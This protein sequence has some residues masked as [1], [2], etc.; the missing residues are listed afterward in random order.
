M[1]YI[2]HI[3]LSL[4]KGWEWC[5]LILHCFLIYTVFVVLCH[6]YV[7]YNAMHKYYINGICCRGNAVASGIS[8]CLMVELHQANLSSDHQKWCSRSQQNIEVRQGTLNKCQVFTVRP[9]ALKSWLG[10]LW[11]DGHQTR[12]VKSLRLSTLLLGVWL[13]AVCKTDKAKAITHQS[14]CI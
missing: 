1:Y 5:V 10:K 13:W 7:W 9:P 12:S 3:V 6:K 4:N 11:L 8:W 14:L 2:P